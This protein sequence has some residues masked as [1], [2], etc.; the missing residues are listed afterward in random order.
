M[1][2]N[3]IILYNQKIILLKTSLIPLEKLLQSQK[4]LKNCINISQK[5]I[6]EL[7]KINKITKKILK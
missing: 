4:R 1:E 3:F 6:K 2:I 7:I 5:Y